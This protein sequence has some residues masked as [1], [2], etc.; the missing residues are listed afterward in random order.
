MKSVVSFFLACLML[1]GSL[2]PQN[3]LAELS[4]LPQLLEH[5]RFHHSV[6]GGGLSVGQFMAEHYGSGTPVHFGCTFSPRHQQDHQGLPLH[7]Q[8]A[9]SAHVAFLLLPVGVRLLPQR[10]SVANPAYRPAGQPRY[11]DGAAPALLQPPRA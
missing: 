2:I 9:C 8:H 10:R 5:Y 4:K 11:Q 3:D 1:V 7:G 6:A